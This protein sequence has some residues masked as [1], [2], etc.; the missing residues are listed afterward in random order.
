MGFLRKL[1]N[2]CTF[3]AIDRHDAKKIKNQANEDLANAKE[4]LEDKRSKTEKSIEKLG[5]AKLTAYSGALEKFYNCYT[6]ISKADRKPFKR[7]TDTVSYKDVKHS[8]ITISKTQVSLKKVALQSAGAISTGALVAGGTYFAVKGLVFGK[9]AGVAAKNATV[10]WL[11]GGSL[12][13]G[14]A[15][16]AGGMVVLGGIALAPVALFSMYMGYS[17]GKRKLNDA[18]NYADEVEVFVQKVKTLICELNQIERAAKLFTKAII[19]MDAVLEVQND[20]LVQVINRLQGRT[21]F[22]KAIRD[23][24]KKF[25]RK[26]IFEPE[27]LRV[28]TD[29][30]NCAVLLSGLIEKPL[31]D[32]NGAFISSSIEFIES[33]NKKADTYKKLLKA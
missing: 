24:I 32:D 7:P 6:Q 16:M 27:E 26:N 21:F 9:L 17:S 18:M 10:A 30:I 33:A 1:G 8:L 2:F 22:Q 31:M 12:A 19:S 3:G 5:N 14:G 11:G 4:E 23:P 15:G 13:S 29:S 28:I 20:K 25:F